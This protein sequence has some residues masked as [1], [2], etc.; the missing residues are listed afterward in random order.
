MLWSG[1]EALLRIL[2]LSLEML[3]LNVDPFEFY[4][5]FKFQFKY[6]GVEFLAFFPTP[7]LLHGTE[8]IFVQPKHMLIIIGKS[9]KKNLSI[10]YFGS[11]QLVYIDLC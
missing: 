4:S 9:I 8:T 11:R 7:D 1:K 3:L 5:G 2:L 10:H 6:S